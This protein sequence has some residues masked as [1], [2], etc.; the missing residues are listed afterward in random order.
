[1]AKLE[2]A[3]T[4][5]LWSELK[6]TLYE[7]FPL[8][9]R[10]TKDQGAPRMIHGLIE[11]GGAFEKG[12]VLRGSMAKKDL[13]VILAKS[14]TAGV[15]STVEALS[16]VKL[17]DRHHQPNS[18]EGYIVCTQEDGV[19]RAIL[20]AEYPFLHMKVYGPDD[21]KAYLNKHERHEGEKATL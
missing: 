5:L 4:H 17:I 18:I 21:I 19:L 20:N 6:G 16:A 11:K 7:E 2:T 12:D 15:F 10:G 8:A 3:L 9:I 1:M 14:K 13:I